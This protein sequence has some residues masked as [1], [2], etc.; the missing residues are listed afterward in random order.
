MS[1]LKN[2]PLVEY[3][4]ELG[5]KMV[6]FAG[7]NMPVQYEGI[8][9]EHRHTRSRCSVFDICHMGEFRIAGPGAAQAV[10]RLLLRPVADQKV[11][12][13]RYNLLLTPEGGVLDD[14]IVYRMEEEDF[15]IVVNAGNTALDAAEFKAKLPEGIEFQDLSAD[16]A[17]LDL[18]G[19][20]SAK[21]LAELGVAPADLPAYFHWTMTEVDGIRC[22]LSRTGY[23]GELGFELYFDEEYADQLWDLLLSTDPVMPAGLGARDTLRLEMGYPLHGHE[24]T[25]ELSPID[26]GLGHFVRL[27]DGRDFTGRE[28]LRSRPVRRQMVGVR[29]ENR[30]AARAGSAVMRSNEEVIGVVTSGA[31]CPSLDVAAA[32]CSI[33]I[34]CR[35]APGDKVL[36]EA[37]QALLPGTVTELPFYTRG[38]VRVKVPDSDR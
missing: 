1:A 35:L 16:L 27:D 23:T 28:A 38:S 32:L 13:C 26:S 36:L 2:T 19:P 22:I 10:D 3:H 24:L 6:P 30:R 15:F 25:R 29:L 33:D 12:S 4:I 20:D 14:L 7:W 37:G 18:Q 17:K 5:A 9:A 31:F 11:G 21:V 8:L 34:E